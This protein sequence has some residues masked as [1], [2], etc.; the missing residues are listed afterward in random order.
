MAR[1][2]SAGLLVVALSC[3]GDSNELTGP[4]NPPPANPPLDDQSAVVATE[5]VVPAGGSASLGTLDR[6]LAGLA[7]LSDG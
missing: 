7:S 5:P 2:A 1:L 6:G 4:S 3:S